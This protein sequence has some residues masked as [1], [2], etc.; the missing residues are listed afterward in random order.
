MESKDP[1]LEATKNGQRAGNLIWAAVAS[2]GRS[3]RT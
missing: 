1:T 2:A 3:S